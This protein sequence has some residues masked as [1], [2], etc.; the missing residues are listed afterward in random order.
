MEELDS[1]DIIVTDRGD[2][3][4]TLAV[5]SSARQLFNKFLASR[6]LHG[7]PNSLTITADLA[8]IAT[9]ECMEQLAGY[10]LSI[11]KQNGDYYAH[12]SLEV[13]F[14]KIIEIVEKEASQKL[15]QPRF[16]N[17]WQSK[18]CENLVRKAINRK[19]DEGIEEIAKPSAGRLIT[20]LISN[21]LFCH[22]KME[23]IENRASIVVEF[24]CAG[25]TAEGQ[26]CLD[27]DLRW[28][29]ET[30]FVFITWRD[31]K[32]NQ[33]YSIPVPDD[34]SAWSLSFYN[35]IACLRI[36]GNGER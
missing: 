28:C 36:V 13:Y 11:K 32:T 4:S 6:T 3:R 20:N 10:L 26:Y 8:V 30:S 5:T 18:V 19:I 9:K 12:S 1:E 15:Q 21:A 31:H 35:V 27:E 2:A 22:N 16:D 25:R 23:G 34:A 24:K 14:N 7:V 33:L 17:E 29:N